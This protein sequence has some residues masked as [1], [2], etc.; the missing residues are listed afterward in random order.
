MI[1]CVSL[2]NEHLLISLESFSGPFENR[3]CNAASWFKR[4]MVHVFQFVHWMPKLLAGCL[5]N[6][7]VKR[8]TMV[9]KP[10]IKIVQTRLLLILHYK[11]CNR[12]N[13]EH[14]EFKIYIKININ[15]IC[16][17]MLLNIFIVVYWIKIRLSSTAVVFFGRVLICKNIDWQGN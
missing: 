14:W 12:N 2:S 10:R 1:N 11:S 16:W 6:F 13:A 15:I 9:Q 7:V 8:F 3:S 4:G 5:C 17:N